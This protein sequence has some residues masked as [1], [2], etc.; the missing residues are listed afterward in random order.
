MEY[1]REPQGKLITITFLNHNVFNE[2]DEFN[3]FEFIIHVKLHSS[4]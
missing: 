1:L 3:V 2:F 4:L